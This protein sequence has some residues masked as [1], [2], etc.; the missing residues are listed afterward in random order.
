[1][2]TTAGRRGARMRRALADNNGEVD[3][4][5]EQWLVSVLMVKNG[6]MSGYHSG[7]KESGW[8][9]CSYDLIVGV[10]ITRSQVKRRGEIDESSSSSGSSLCHRSH[11]WPRI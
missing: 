9:G 3:G 4:T 6:I 5:R 1:M 10:V 11:F 7:Y 8:A 2:T